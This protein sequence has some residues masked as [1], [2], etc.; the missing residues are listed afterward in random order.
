[1]KN[2]AH[3][4]HF[5]DAACIHDSNTIGSFGNDAEVV[6]NQQQREAECRL[7]LA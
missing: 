6:R 4:T 2:P 1:M 7:H 3:G 5:D